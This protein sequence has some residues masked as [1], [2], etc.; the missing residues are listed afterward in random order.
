M[1]AIRYMTGMCYCFEPFKYRAVS[2]INI[3]VSGIE[4]GVSGYM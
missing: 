4:I 1:N 3:Q 2:S